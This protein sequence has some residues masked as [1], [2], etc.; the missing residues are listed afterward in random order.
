MVFQAVEKVFYVSH[1]KKNIDVVIYCD[2]GIN[3]LITANFL[4]DLGFDNV[5]NLA[6]GIEAWK[7]LNESKK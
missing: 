1:I 5:Y 7:N 4:N 6:G 2:F 3:S